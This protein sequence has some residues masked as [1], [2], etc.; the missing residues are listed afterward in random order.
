[1][2]LNSTS[3]ESLE[4][5]YLAAH[6]SALMLKQAQPALLHVSGPDALDLL[7]R[8]STNELMQIGN[9]DVQHTIFTNANARIIEVVTVIPEEQ[10][11]LL[12]C[13]HDSP[14]IL[15][16]W[17]SGYIF[18][19]D[20]VQLSNGTEDWQLIDF[21]GPNAAE[22]V[23]QYSGFEQY[24]G[25]GFRRV[26]FGYLWSQPLASLP[27][28]RL[29]CRDTLVDDI[30]SSMEG[31]NPMVQDHALMEILRIEAGLPGLESEI[32][33]DSIPL[34]VGLW[35]YISFSKGC[36][37][38]QEIIARMESRGK[39]ARKLVGLRSANELFVG[40][41]LTVEG[42]SIGAITSVAL[43]PRLGWIGLAS[44]KPGRWGEVAPVSAG[45]SKDVVLQELP[46]D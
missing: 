5:H 15:R 42:K 17:L 8:M 20:D 23:Q 11:F 1:M 37:I 3:T 44:V 12:M 38:G 36:Y 33:A 24:A 19:Q 27:R 46:F 21:V 13:W 18:F 41:P 9:A 35:E 2:T 25:T 7:N 16:G 30:T 26:K 43:S 14:D 32:Q 40:T 45:D 6:K 31:S 10:E 4:T 39:Q 22:L 34:E 28:F 29:L